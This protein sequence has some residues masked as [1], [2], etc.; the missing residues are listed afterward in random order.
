[1][2]RQTRPRPVRPRRLHP[3][4]GAEP[5]DAP[6]GAATL[7]RPAISTVTAP[8][9]PVAATPAAPVKI[10]TTDYGYVVGELKRIAVLTLVILV[11]LAGFSFVVT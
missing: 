7:S 2:A 3:P 9:R 1:M 11:L 5:Q 10:T 6:T 8:A 4:H